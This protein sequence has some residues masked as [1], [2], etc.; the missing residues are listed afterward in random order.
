MQEVELSRRSVTRQVLE[1]HGPLL[2]IYVAVPSSVQE[3]L[4][5]SGGIVHDPISTMA[6]IDTGSSGTLVR[7]SIVS[8][9]GLNPVGTGQFKTPQSAGMPSLR[10][11]VRLMFPAMGA[12][13]ELGVDTADL[14]D[15]P[16]DCIIGR[17][18]LSMGVFVYIGSRK[19]FTLSF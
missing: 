5:G 15:E 18:L 9:L 16:F 1:P 11:L 8:E 6:L 7:R 14:P 4:S 12:H 2:E 3:A 13:K 19:E 17:N 10:Y